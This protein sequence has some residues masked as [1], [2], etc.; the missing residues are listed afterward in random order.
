MQAAKVA[1]P[2]SAGPSSANASNE[3]SVVDVAQPEEGEDD[4]VEV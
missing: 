3:A 2:T 4:V 1:L